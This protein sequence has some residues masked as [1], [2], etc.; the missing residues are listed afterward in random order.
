MAS[1][2][3]LKNSTPI[4]TSNIFSRLEGEEPSNEVDEAT[5]IDAAATLRATKVEI[6]LGN[7]ISDNEQDLFRVQGKISDRRVTMLMGSGATHDFISEDLVKKLDLS[8]TTNTD[9]LNVTL[10]DGSSRSQSKQITEPLKT[11]VGDFAL[12]R[13][14][15]T[16]SRYVPSKTQPRCA[17]TCG[18]VHYLRLSRL[19][20]IKNGRRG[21][22]R[23]YNGS[24]Q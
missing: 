2:P 7:I 15:R 16:A 12:T 19:P 3:A 17:A 21:S 5:E 24:R 13:S 14:H 23:V 6:S 9:V 18:G 1:Q 20:R 11:V 8:T 22:T 4:Q 10:P